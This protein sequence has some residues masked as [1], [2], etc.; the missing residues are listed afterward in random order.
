MSL[1]GLNVFSVCFVSSMGK[2]GLL[3]LLVVKNIEFRFSVFMFLIL[4]VFSIM[5]LFFDFLIVYLIY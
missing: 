3:L 2:Y 4:I 5:W 1:I